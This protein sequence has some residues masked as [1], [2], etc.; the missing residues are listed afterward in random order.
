V[1]AEHAEV[2]LAEYGIFSSPVKAVLGN[3]VEFVQ[4]EWKERRLCVDLAADLLESEIV[5]WLRIRRAFVRFTAVES[6]TAECV[7]P[8]LVLN[9]SGKTK[10]RCLA[11]VRDATLS[12][13]N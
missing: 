6:V 3:K 12:V 1:I 4:L 10:E 5:L 11:V 7:L 13:S 8:D 2:V 9:F